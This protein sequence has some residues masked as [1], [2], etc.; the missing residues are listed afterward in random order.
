MSHRFPAQ[1]ANAFSPRCRHVALLAVGLLVCH[2][3]GGTSRAAD[4]EPLH[5][6]ID[7]LMEAARLGPVAEPCT[8]AAFLRRSSLNLVGTIPSADEARAFLDDPS[9]GKRTALVDR[10]LGDPRHAIHMA[11][12]FDVMLMERRGGNEVKQEDWWNYLHQSFAQDKPWNV[13]A[14]EILSAD[15][16]DPAQ[17]AAAKFYLERGEPNL[18][19][20][21]VG[22]IFFGKDV[23]CAQCHDHPL[24][25]NYRQRDYYGLFAFVNRVSLFKDAKLKANVVAEKAEGDASF[26]SVFTG[27]AGDTRPRLPG[28]LE[29]DEPS[30]PPGEEYT[31]K[32]AKDVRPVPKYSRLARLAEEA[33]QGTNAAFNRNIA[34]RLWALMMGRG[35]VEPVD[36]LHPENPPSHPEVLELVASEFATGGFQIKPL[37]RELALTQVYQRSVELPATMAGAAADLAARLPELQA[38]EERLEAELEQAAAQVEQASEPL[39]AARKT[40]SEVTAELAKSTAALAEAKKAAEPLQKAFA[41]IQQQLAPRRELAGLVSASS[42]KAAEALAKLPDDAE[43][44]AAVKL[45]ESRSSKLAAEVAALEKTA[46]ERETA[47]AG[48]V[49]KVGAVEKT[50]AESNAKLPPAQAAV[51]EADRQ[52]VAVETER[53]R[54]ETLANLA[55]L[56]VDAAAALV[57]YGEL[58]AA[59]SAAAVELAALTKQLEPQAAQLAALST[60]RAQREQALTEAKQRLEASTTAVQQTT[61]KLAAEREAAGALA[62]ASSATASALEKLSGEAELKQAATILEARAASVGASA[63]ELEKALATHQAQV[64]EAQTQR[65]AVQAAFEKLTAQVEPLKAQVERARAQHA[66]LQQRTGDAR[67]AADKAWEELAEHW[68]GRAAVAPLRALTPEQLAWSTLQAT[69]LVERQRAASTAELDKKDP[70]AKEAAESDPA[71]RAARDAVIERAVYDKLKANVALF[72]SLFGGAAG[73]PQNQFYATVDQALFFA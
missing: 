39:A 41:E 1:T 2:G 21:D 19:T 10:L 47:A 34:N 45:I 54:R 59:E 33:S 42:S 63:A 56:R 71:V 28:G 69:G 51:A 35:L 6:R 55:E 8:D 72:T 60:E 73:E 53:K 68:T 22:R 62:A 17:R 29:L 70:K 24:I 16:V 46:G 18:L 66:S 4:D 49:A 9:P 25:D 64:R 65:D 57:E 36:L 40:L 61:A 12:V 20:R 52:F 43:L 7:R 15:G 27:E 11:D 3:M 48:A 13:L 14:R 58:A 44:A 31:V 32:P 30:F 26:K 37:L 5:V 67:A 50:I 38:E 23:Q